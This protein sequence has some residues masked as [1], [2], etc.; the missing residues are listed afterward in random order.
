MISLRSKEQNIGWRSN[1]LNLMQELRKYRRS[2]GNSQP[3]LANT[4]QTKSF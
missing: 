1:A 2:D 3:K 4:R